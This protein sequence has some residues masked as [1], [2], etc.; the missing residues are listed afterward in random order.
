MFLGSGRRRF[1]AEV[2]R[3]F[4]VR[5]LKAVAF[6][7]TAGLVVPAVASAAT[8]NVAPGRHDDAGQPSGCSAQPRN[9]FRCLT[10]RDAIAF[11]N[12]GLAGANPT[13]KLAA[14][15]YTLSNGALTLTVP[16]TVSGT[17]DSGA[18]ASTIRQTGPDIVLRASNALKLNSLVVTGAN[19]T[20]PNATTGSPAV[21]PGAAISVNGSLA[22]NRVAV[23]GNH[24]VG[25]AGLAQDNTNQFGT[26]GSVL[27]S[28]IQS[29]GALSISNSIV[30]G[31]TAIG[32]AGGS[33]NGVNPGGA[34]NG[35]VGAIFGVGPV[36]IA[37]SKITNNSAIGG[38]G[39]A[40]TG[41]GEAGAGGAAV[42]TITSAGSMSITGS[43]ISGNSATGG[44]GGSAAG[45]NATG[46]AGGAA[47]GV[48][49]S[50]RGQGQTLAVSNT[51]ISGNTA[52]GGAGG[53][54]TGEGGAGGV[55]GPAI[56]AALDML[57]VGVGTASIA[58]STIA[59]NTSS[60]GL[61]G[62]DTAQSGAGGFGGGAD[63]AIDDSS[64]VA[65]T[66]PSRGIPLRITASTLSGNQAIGSAGGAGGAGGS[67]GIAGVAAGGA[68]R[69]ASG[70]TVTIV[71]STIFANSV[72]SAGG[73]QF[74]GL[75]GSFG[76]GIQ[77]A[78]PAGTGVSLFSDT[79]AANSAS[80]ALGP[81]AIFG[82]NLDASNQGAF[83]LESTAVVSL[84]PGSGGGCS[85]E[86][87]TYTDLGRNLQDAVGTGC[88]L[89]GA[90]LGDQLVTNSGLSNRLGANGGPT[91]TLAPQ[92]GSA[93]IG[94]GGVCA[95]PIGGGAIV[96]LRI[97]Q[98]GL[99]RPIC[100]I[101]AFQTQ[102][103]KLTGKPKVT[104][105]PAVGRTLT[106]ANGTLVV[107]GDGIL[108]AAGA[109]GA[110][111]T[112]TSFASNGAQVSQRNTYTVRTSDQGHS[113]TCSIAVTGAYGQ[114]QAT[115]AAVNV[116]KPG[117][118]G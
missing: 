78:G 4:W 68:L 54:A 11:A 36:S 77:V 42:G 50:P 79:V 94:N 105:T 83:N 45:A 96:P 114:A 15:T 56:G 113:I 67:T 34:G 33:S 89:G 9:S 106:C 92:P 30:S 100:D 40:N 57:S 52:N 90:G 66:I 1:K 81:Q 51:T 44:A 21:M 12:A 86:G 29:N 87:G 95:N 58:A 101:G 43:T 99:P 32:G 116:A 41:G 65:G 76:G 28:A 97:D 59:N 47:A 27:G 71:N 72:Q 16:L 20:G 10:L 111:R 18:G 110:R 3:G 115:S 22:L 62:A 69:A 17:G 108:T 23:V 53:T 24:A 112:K 38:A 103:I 46:G 80:A 91:R 64:Q 60:A 74:P 117:R 70:A 25:G 93:V 104:G 85:T 75:S 19:A 13:V 7:V 63:G 49:F 31:N 73:A 14:G 82:P 5:V 39:G 35:A 98:R 102:P 26:G 55:G 88:G 48:S 8:L 61:A 37:N 118:R 109:I 84:S 6:A 2:D 107:T